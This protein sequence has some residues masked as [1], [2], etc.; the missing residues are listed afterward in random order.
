MR[1]KVITLPALCALS[2]GLVPSPATAQKVEVTYDKSASFKQYKRYAWG[3]NSLVTRQTAEVEAEIEKKIEASADRALAAKGLIKDD[4]KPDFLIR[5]DAGA[6]PN[7]DGSAP[8]Y[9]VPVPG[10][11]G[12]FV[13]GT[14]SGVSAD[15]WLQV[16]GMLK[17]SIQDAP[18]KA[19]VW[20]SLVTK[21]TN[22][23]KKFLRNLDSEIDKMASKG[24]EKFPPK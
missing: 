13:E 16:S 8:G 23:P 12:M 21:K 22:D 7:P 4:A 11:G 15:I 14:F 19:T 17:F 6:M 3:K 9:K 20:Q 18:S 1:W 24:L 10:G 5:Y 2:L